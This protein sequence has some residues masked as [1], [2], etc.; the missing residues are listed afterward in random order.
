MVSKSAFADLVPYW[1]GETVRDLHREYGSIFKYGNRNAA[2][3]LWSAFLLDRSTQMSGKKL[4]SLFR[5]FCAISGSPV[6]PSSYNRYRLS[7]PKASGGKSIGYMQYC[8]WPC[9]CDTQDFIFVDTKTVETADGPRVFDFAVIGNPCN[10]SAKLS[11]PFVQPFDGRQTTLLREAPEIR[12]HDGELLGAPI[13]DHGH[14]ILSMFF[15]AQDV[16]EEAGSVAIRSQTPQPGR[17]STA[18]GIQFQDEME[19]EDM[20][21]DRARA[22][23]N[24]GM[25]EIFRKVAAISPLKSLDSFAE[26]R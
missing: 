9:V 1:G 12:C 5:G 7:L 10:N 16:D 8:C 21:V 20:C 18:N 26:L 22:G 4:E 15:D 2:S 23:Y 6:N 24:S 14:V 13:S 17:I 25:G 19:F 3:H 11:V